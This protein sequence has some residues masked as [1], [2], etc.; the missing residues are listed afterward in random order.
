MPV[1]QPIGPMPRK[2]PSQ[3]RRRPHEWPSL[4]LPEPIVDG[5]SPYGLTIVRDLERRRLGRG[6]VAGALRRWTTFAKF[7]S[8]QRDQFLRHR[9]G[10]EEC[11][12][13]PY[14][15][16]Q[17]LETVVHAL[18]RRDARFLRDR[19]ARLDDRIAQWEEIYER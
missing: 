19:F 1:C 17:L 6:A 2:R 18:P 3:V 16:R 14:V 13:S 15:D 10:V 11:C 7:S 9:C 4:G 12:P 8:R 5:L